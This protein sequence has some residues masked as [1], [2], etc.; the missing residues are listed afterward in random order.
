MLSGVRPSYVLFVRHLLFSSKLTA[1]AKELATPGIVCPQLVLVAAVRH[2]YMDATALSMGGAR[3]TYG[4]LEARAELLAR[5]L[6]SLGVG[7]EIV[8]GVSL[9][10]S[11]EYVIA[12]LAVWKAGGAYVPVDLDWPEERRAFVME[13]ARAAVVIGHGLVAYRG[14]VHVGPVGRRGDYARE[15]GVHHLYIGIDRQTE[16]RRGYAG[17]FIEPGFLAPE[18]VRRD[19]GRQ[20][21]SRGRTGVRRGGVGAVAVS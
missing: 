11:F 15:S 5:N 4:E 7:P 16:G 10:R 9:E 21:E 12:V 18:S 3:L 14:E 1:C 2:G 8:A 19:G 20:G 17:E 13:D 6:K